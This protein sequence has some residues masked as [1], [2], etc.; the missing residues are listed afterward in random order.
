VAPCDGDGDG[1]VAV[2]TGE[3]AP[4]ANRA[5]RRQRCQKKVA[6][7]LAILAL[8]ACVGMAASCDSGDCSPGAL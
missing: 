6:K 7:R 3:H 1:A 5:E 8:L 4:A 2:P